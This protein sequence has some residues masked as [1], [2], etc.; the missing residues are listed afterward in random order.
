MSNFTPI[1]RYTKNRSKSVSHFVVSRDFVDYVLAEAWTFC[2]GFPSDPQRDIYI[3]APQN[4]DTNGLLPYKFVWEEVSPILYGADTLLYDPLALFEGKG[5][6]VYQVVD[7][8]AILATFCRA[9]CQHKHRT[10]SIHP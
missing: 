10:K 3:F 9:S 8:S 5:T 6:F 1:H 4:R 2:V 7:S